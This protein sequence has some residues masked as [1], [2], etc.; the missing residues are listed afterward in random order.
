MDV[1]IFPQGREGVKVEYT[2]PEIRL[3]CN[4]L[5]ICL[6]S[7]GDTRAKTSQDFLSVLI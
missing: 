3:I 7:F 2:V 5:P 1:P 4:G 6:T